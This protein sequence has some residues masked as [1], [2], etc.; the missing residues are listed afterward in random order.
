M[1]PP[2]EATCLFYSLRCYRTGR[3]CVLPGERPRRPKVPCMQFT[4]CK[5]KKVLADQNP[6]VGRVEQLERR[7]SS[8]EK[9]LTNME[10]ALTSLANNNNTTPS[11]AS[12]EPDMA[13]ETS[14]STAELIKAPS[15]VTSNDNQHIHDVIDLKFL[16][17]EQADILCRNYR[18]FAHPNFPYIILSQDCTASYLR[19]HKPMLLLII[20]AVTSWR[21][22]SLQLALEQEYLKNLS[23]RLLIRGEKSLDLLQSLLVYVGW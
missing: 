11:L 14:M 9:T 22:R 17:L 3:E 12:T 16:S 15:I 7:L 13:E 18:E 1:L 8:M 6:V 21:E 10:R 23:H 19:I 5:K 2:F 4:I 20:L